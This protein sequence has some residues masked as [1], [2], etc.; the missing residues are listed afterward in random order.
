MS[1]KNTIKV[2]TK[3]GRELPATSGYFHM[4]KRIKG[5]TVYKYLR[6]DCKECRN[7]IKREHYKD[8]KVKKQ[9]RESHADWRK[10]NPD[11]AKSYYDPDKAREEY[12]RKKKSRCNLD[13]RLASQGHCSC[14]SD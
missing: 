11:K 10:R 8:P 1:A 2:C 3:C 4:T 14:M 9:Y 6:S 12:E 5:G 13:G 7:E